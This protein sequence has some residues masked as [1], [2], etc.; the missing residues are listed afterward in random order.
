MHRTGCH[1]SPRHTPRTTQLL[2]HP[3]HPPLSHQALSRNTGLS[4]GS[5]DMLRKQL[6]MCVCVGGGGSLNES[7]VTLQRSMAE[8]GASVASTAAVPGGPAPEAAVHPGRPGA[9]LAALPL[10]SL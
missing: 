7:S 4:S 6:G 8:T 2:E 3:L 5:P 1:P 9:E 10:K